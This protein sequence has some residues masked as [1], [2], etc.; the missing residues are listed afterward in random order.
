MDYWKVRNS[1]PAWMNLGSQMRSTRRNR[2]NVITEGIESDYYPR[3]LMISRYVYRLLEDKYL[4][5]SIS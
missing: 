4:V 3:M 1:D 2:N 5:K